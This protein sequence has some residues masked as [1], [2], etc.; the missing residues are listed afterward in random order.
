MIIHS[1]CPLCHSDSI[2]SHFPVT[3]HSVSGEAFAVWHCEQCTV[4]FTHEVPDEKEMGR[5]YASEAYV[6]HTNSKRGMINRL[7]H[8]VRNV[9]LRKKR[10]WV[11]SATGLRSGALLDVGCGTG[12]FLSTMKKGGWAVTGIEPDAGARQQASSLHA[13]QPL[14]PEA[15]DILA[16]GSFHA[17][18][19]WHV[20]EHV[21]ALHHYV[22]RIKKLLAPSGKIFIAVPNHTSFDASYYRQQWAAWDVPRHLYHF[23]PASMEILLEKHGLKITGILPMR[24]DS[25][26]VS[27]LSEKYMKRPTGPLNALFIGFIS[28]LVA[29]FCRKKCSSLVYVVE[30]D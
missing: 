16:E 22:G 11:E 24:F 4:M 2:R 6:S 20:L 1:K 7:Y 27:L 3:D 14:G 10:R 30:A 17:I 9:T 23:S 19:L 5:Y 12:A 25:Y 28:N 18:T 26:Y 21:H 15:I 29:L 8:A 13:I